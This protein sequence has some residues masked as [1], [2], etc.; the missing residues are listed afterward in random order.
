M[1]CAHPRLFSCQRGN[2]GQAPS[3]RGDR[4]AFFAIRSV[5]RPGGSGGEGGGSDEEEEDD[6][7]GGQFGEPCPPH[8]FRAFAALEQVQ[9][10][11]RSPVRTEGGGRCARPIISLEKRARWT[12]LA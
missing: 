1:S 12:P 8:L 9:A 2:H 7:E 5:A 6:E 4:V 10:P 3:T 11:C